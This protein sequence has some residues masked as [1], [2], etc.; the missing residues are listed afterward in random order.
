MK[1]KK[2]AA[3]LLAVV[4]AF[5]LCV[6]AFADTGSNATITIKN[7]NSNITIVGKTFSAYKL[8]D[9]NYNATD[10][11]YAYTVNS[12]FV[13]FF[14]AEIPTTATGAALDKAAYDYVYAFSSDS[15]ALLAF[16]DDAYTWIGNHS[17]S[18]TD[19]ATGAA[20]TPE[21]AVFD[22]IDVFGYYLVYAT[23]YETASGTGNTVV[24]AYICDTSNSADTSIFIKADA[25]TVDKDV[26]T[27]GTNY[28]E[29]AVDAG[30]GDTVYFRYESKVPD[31]YGYDAYTFKFT[32]EL[33]AGLTYDST[34]G[35]V[36]KINNVA[37]ASGAYSVNY[38][39]GT[40]TVEILN[41]LSYAAQEGQTIEVFY[42]ATVNANGLD[43][44]NNK[45]D[46][47]YSNDPEG[48]TTNHTPD[49]EVHV[50]NYRIPVLKYTVRNEADVPL[51]G[52]EF[53][54]TI[55]GESSP[56]S[57]VLESGYYRLAVAGDSTTTTTLISGT[58]GKISIRGLDAGTYILEETKAPEGYNLLT[59]T[60]TVTITATTTSGEP[61]GGCTITSKF[62]SSS[63]DASTVTQIA[64]ENTTGVELPST[65]GIGTTLFT[66]G[67]ILIILFAGAFLVIFR[68]KVFGSEK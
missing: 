6:P 13:G 27:D 41:F 21:T 37:L 58:D 45:V 5:A 60:I 18:A 52:A 34:T 15:A 30:L 25:P 47:E 57:F 50:Y 53:T 49:S 38:S 19:T 39:S 14:Q 35:V 9:L 3:V 59:D 16:A 10:D 1:I 12:A 68:K 23:A 46:L 54:L 66:L 4:L 26:S 24:S 32:D 44:N 63:G 22:E 61:N 40:L 42:Q 36:V 20:G 51:A 17:I 43:V 8:F 29:L 33:S 55:D 31:M 65:G 28:N 56:L 48:T 2:F 64:V 11:A 67:G 7:D 62:T